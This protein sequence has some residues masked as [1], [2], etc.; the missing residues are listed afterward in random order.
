MDGEH[1]SEARLTYGSFN[2]RGVDVSVGGRN[3]NFSYDFGL[4]LYNSDEAGIEDYS[5]WGIQILTFCPTLLFGV[6]VTCSP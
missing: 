6:L 2:S 1:R 3:G 5:A 4:K